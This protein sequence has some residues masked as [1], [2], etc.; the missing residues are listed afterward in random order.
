MHDESLPRCGW[1][2]STDALYCAY[3]DEEWGVAVY[4]SKALFGKLMLDGMQ[5]G[6]AWI[7][8]LRKREA[9][10]QA[11]DG[12]DPDLVA[13]YTY[14]DRDRLLGNAGIIRSRLKINSVISNAQIFCQMRDEENLDFSEY[15]WTFVGGAPIVN[16]W[17][18]NKDVPVTSVQAE[19]LAKDLRKR[20]FKFTGPVIV[21]AFMQAVGMIN[22]HTLNCH[23]RQS[24]S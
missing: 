7:T 18:D 11:F 22:D 16:Q 3:H 6:L 5:A 12:L 13:H 8:I 23:C 9:I 24:R 4:D 19:T 20:G 15:L 14:K 10:I 2:P 1:V 17:K 21:Y